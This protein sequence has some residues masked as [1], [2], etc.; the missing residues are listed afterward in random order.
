MTSF[1]AAGSAVL[2]PRPRRLTPTSGSAAS[3]AHPVHQPDPSL[4]AE[5]YVLDIGDQGT[6]LRHADAAGLRYGTETLRQLRHQFGER[7]PGLRIE[8]HPDLRVRG[9]MLDISRGR[10]PTMGYLRRLVDLLALLRINQL[11]LYT[12]HTFAYAA[13][14]VVWR[15]ASPL[16]AEEVCQVDAWCQ[17][18]GIELV[19]NQNCFGHME[20]WLAHEPYRQ[21]AEC[22]DGYQLHGAHRAPT[23]LEPTEASADLALSLFHELLANFTSRTVNIGCDETQEV[24]R[25]RSAARVAQV[26]S[27]EVYVEHLLRLA[28][29][30]VQDGFQ[31]QFWGDMLYRHPDV[32]GRLPQGVMPVPWTYEAARAVEDLPLAVRNRM[33]EAGVDAADFVS[34]FAPQI[35]TFAGA[36]FP[37]LVAPGTS[38]WSS[39]IGRLD[40]AYGNLDD[41]ADSARRAGAQGVLI[42]EWGDGG[43][44]QPPSAGFPPIAY[45]AAQAWCRTANQDLDVAAALDA[46]VFA[47]DGHRLGAMLDT[48]GRLWART[49]RVTFNSSPINTALLS[50]AASD[51]PPLDVAATR[52]ALDTL[53]QALVD[54]AAARPQAPDGPEVTTE[55]A[56]ALRLARHGVWRLLREADAPRPT[57][58]EL[59]ADLAEAIDAHV[60]A[61]DRRSRP[62]GREIGEA[63]LR[64][65]LAE[66]AG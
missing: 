29:P 66:Y 47:D 12:E 54:A 18:A 4:P 20:H 51:P 13:H 34:G 53:E 55:L 7:I 64:A 40:N 3:A 15:D 45:G 63:R 32:M 50:P 60:A 39:L 58:A 33:A 14:E 9:Y 65:T 62:G 44:L 48:V 56:A 23:T 25:G 61:W 59:R 28:T 35:P 16:T 10:V 6:S 21:L 36:P 57:D 49:G 8:D 26:G 52:S 27:T 19:A 2:L 31:V 17:E 24:G 22:P 1:P 38:T 11:Q 42:T 5:G 43:H 37:F 41:A 30:L 46:H